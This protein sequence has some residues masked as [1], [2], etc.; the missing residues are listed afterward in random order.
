MNT[1]TPP[2]PLPGQGAPAALWP[3]LQ[4]L[5][6]P[7]LQPPARLL[8]HRLARLPG[9]MLLLA[10]CLCLFLPGGAGA[11]TV[12]VALNLPT[13]VSADVL[14]GATTLDLPFAVSGADSLQFDLIVPVDGASLALLDPSGAEVLAS[15]DP[16]LAF[17]PGS[18][19]TP[20]LPG[21]VFVAATLAAPAD[22][23]WTLRLRFPAASGPTAVLGT[24]MA[25]SRYQAGIA[26]ERTTLLVGEDVSIGMVVLDNGRPITGLAPTI[27]VGAAAAV[28]ASD[29]GHAPDGL[30]D[31]G[32]YSIDHT[33][34]AP[35]LVDIKA[36]VSIPTANGP[37]L[38]LASAQVRA[39][40][41]LLSA[42]AVRLDTL[43]GV[44]DCVS[45]LRVGVDFSVLAPATY[46]TLV[47]L[48]A[49]NGRSIDVRKSMAMGAAGATVEASFS[50]ADI[51]SRLASDGPYTVSRIDTL[52]LGG[53]ELLLAFR[54]LDAGSFDVALAALCTPPILLE[55]SLVFTPLLSDGYIASFD[56]SFPV[57]I[58][59][60]GFYQ[61][62]FKLVGASG[63][64]IELVNA[65]RALTKG[66][67]QVHVNVASPR[68]LLV[69]GPYRAISLL[70]LQGAT[71]ARLSNLGASAAYSRWQFLPVRAG[72]LDGD[73]AVGQADVDTLAGFR[74]V[75]A[76]VPGDRRDLNRDGVIDLRDARLLQ[77]LR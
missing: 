5:L 15:G 32:V 63:A 49:P 3:L 30:A 44:D 58:N 31:D 59:T 16:R 77:S 7:F 9:L 67:N 24:I 43:R 35:G 66:V 36:S 42:S 64:D 28:P 13:S 17:H 20:P 51:R 76:L 48:S 2:L 50:A 61:I 52:Q 75:R 54:R 68:F 1:L 39:V 21:G 10:L 12:P 47:R 38:R 8:A 34:T 22:G 18:A 65:S 19:Q 60:A 33:F 41:P 14:P 11:Q 37:V 69:D 55:A 23:T 26:I 74:G 27:S 45:A 46:A 73:G 70:V 56:L 4:P 71:S 72:D 29:D 40:A 25:R 57:T 6:R 62:S 53:D